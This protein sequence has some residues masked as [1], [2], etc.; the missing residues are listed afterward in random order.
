MP[1]DASPTPVPSP[2]GRCAACAGE[3]GYESGGPQGW[4]PDPC[5]GPPCRHAA[6]APG[7]SPE[8]RAADDVIETWA[9]MAS[10][11]DAE[12]VERDVLR[13]LIIT[14]LGEARAAGSA[15]VAAA[16]CRYC[17]QGAHLV[18]SG[19]WA[20]YHEANDGAGWWYPRCAAT[21]TPPAPGRRGEG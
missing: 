7:P 18:T 2:E 6:A 16:I 17:A 5:Q 20:G 21:P 19:T 4:V 15:A 11:S 12:L 13:E 1:A 14:A 9:R 3:A 8:A 10:L